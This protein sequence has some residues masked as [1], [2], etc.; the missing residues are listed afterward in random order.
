VT[1]TVTVTDT[2][3]QVGQVLPATVI[4]VEQEYK[5][6]LP[7]RGLAG[8]PRPTLD[9]LEQAIPA[10]AESERVLRFRHT[11]STIYFDDRWQ[12]AANGITLR[13]IVNPGEIKDIAWLGIKQTIRWEH[14]CRDSLEIGERMSARSVGHEVRDGTTLP[15]TYLRRQLGPAVQ[16][17]AYAA[18]AQQRH[19]LFYV[20]R[21]GVQLFVT[22]DISEFRVLPQSETTLTYWLEIENNDRELGARHALDRWAHALSERLETAPSKEAK[23][24][25]A[26]TLAGWDPAA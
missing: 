26:A 8:N 3:P 23:A 17:T 6:R 11:Q 10:P 14:G 18:V 4:G 2:D 19:K 9:E 16:P 15:M 5:W 1:G 24:E 12:L 21:D 22:F 13:A 20:D 25:L 7:A